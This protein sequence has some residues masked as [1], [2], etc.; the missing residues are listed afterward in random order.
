M[1]TRHNQWNEV[2]NLAKSKKVQLAYSTPCFEYW[3]L[4]HLKYTTRPIEDGESAKKLIEETFGQPYSTN[5]DETKQAFQQIIVN[6]PEAVK[7]AKRVRE[8]H[9]AGGTDIP[10]NPSTEVD[11]LVQLLNNAAPLHKQRL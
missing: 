2:T 7:R 6:W 9:E 3:V 1:A 8:H 10:A 5:E 11:H 4:L